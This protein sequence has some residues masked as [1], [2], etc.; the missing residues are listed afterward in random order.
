MIDPKK[1]PINPD[2]ASFMWWAHTMEW[3]L[4]EQTFVHLWPMANSFI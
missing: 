3:E 4:F 2:E 1:S